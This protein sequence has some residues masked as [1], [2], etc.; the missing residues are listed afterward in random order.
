[1]GLKYKRSHRRSPRFAG[2][3]LTCLSGHC[4]SYRATAFGAGLGVPMGCRDVRIGEP[5]PD[6]RP[7]EPCHVP[8]LVQDHRT[9][10]WVGG[11]WPVSTPVA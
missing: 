10:L 1:M 5:G 8:E 4:C 9:F 11:Y 6:A 3:K 2:R 7:Y